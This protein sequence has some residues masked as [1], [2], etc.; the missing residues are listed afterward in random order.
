MSFACAKYR[1][2]KVS[3]TFHG[4]DIFAPAAAWLA[5]GTPIKS[6]GPA[7]AKMTQLSIPPPLRRGKTL[8]G[9]VIY[10]DGFGNLVTNIDRA[11]LD[12]F[13]ASFRLTSVLVRIAKGVSVEI[14]P[15]YG[16]APAGAPLAIFGSFE[17]LEIA[18]RDGSAAS[19]FGLAAG[20]PVTAIVTK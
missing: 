18:V 6:L 19:L 4:R 9:E 10:V 16:D 7:L 17:L 1:L 12:A 11:A 14:F 2:G 3:A 13:A 8:A 15:S 20:A 5:S